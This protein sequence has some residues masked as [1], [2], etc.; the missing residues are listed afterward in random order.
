ME[1]AAKLT[2]ELLLIL[3]VE[4]PIVAYFFRRKKRPTVLTV[5]LLVNVLSWVIGTILWLR[6][7]DVNKFYIKMGTSALEAAVYW[8]FLG[9]NWK[10]AILMSLVANTV[11]YIITH[12]VYLPDDFFQKKTNMIR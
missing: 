11:S 7:P 9:R 10:K 12:F 1:T 6:N 3:L 5:A 2:F 4:L 8:Y